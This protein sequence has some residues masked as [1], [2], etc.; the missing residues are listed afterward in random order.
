MGGARAAIGGFESA[1]AGR[2][3][4]AAGGVDRPGRLQRRALGPRRVVRGLREPAPSPLPG[5]CHGAIPPRNLGLRLV[6]LESG[7]RGR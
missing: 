1:A 3:A 2:A 7:A 6:Q 5:P 4:D